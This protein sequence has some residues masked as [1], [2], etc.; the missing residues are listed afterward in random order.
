[1]A[2]RAAAAV[3]LRQMHLVMVRIE[4]E[5]HELLFAATLHRLARVECRR[6]GRRSGMRIRGMM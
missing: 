4:A 6:C 1:M 5:Q 3:R 2:G